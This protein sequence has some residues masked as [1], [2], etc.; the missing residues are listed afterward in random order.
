MGLV[1]AV[2]PLIYDAGRAIDGGWRPVGDEAFVAM[3]IH[4]V[5]GSNTPLI[6][7][8]ARGAEVA[9]LPYHHLGP[10]E[11]WLLA[12]PYRLA[13]GTAAGIVVGVLL[14]NLAAVISIG[15]VARRM[16]G[17]VFAIATL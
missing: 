4:D 16:G 7:M 15:F 6:G 12:G 3:A 11:F 2:L 5:F 17:R 13:G 8:P 10:L 1:L 9:G 14:L